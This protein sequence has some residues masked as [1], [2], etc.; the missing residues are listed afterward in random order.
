[1]ICCAL[2]APL[3]VKSLIGLIPIFRSIGSMCPSSEELIPMPRQV[4]LSQVSGY[5]AGLRISLAQP[6]VLTVGHAATFFF[7]VAGGSIGGCSSVAICFSV[8]AAAFVMPFIS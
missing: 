6:E 8:S 7:V 4:P 5:P 2:R 1:M 3:K